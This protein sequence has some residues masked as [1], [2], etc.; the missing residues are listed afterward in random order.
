MRN[1]TLDAIKGIGIILVVIYHSMGK[2]NPAVFDLDNGLFN[3]IACFFMQMF[4]IVS[5]YL[6]CDKLKE[7]SWVKRHT[8]R[9]FI[10]IILFALLYWVVVKFAP[11][12]IHFR[13]Y[14][15]IAFSTYLSFILYIG[16]GGMILWYLWTT[17][18]CYYAGWILEKVRSKIRVPFWLIVLL[19]FVVINAIPF[20]LFGLAQFKWYSIFFFIGY[21]IKYYKD[22]FV[23]R[24]GKYLVYGC[25]LFPVIGYCLHWMID[26]QTDGGYLGYAN[27]P[28][29]ISSGHWLLIPLMIIMALL[30]T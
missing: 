13:G 22:S 7:F 4:L 12:I 24:N 1:A 17:I 21:L 27:I 18:L 28:T 30:G 9:W 20:N 3:M 15:D 6:A 14:Y 2:N 29:L 16:F 11:S 26:S 19:F 23:I 8:F 10:P 5:G 25:L